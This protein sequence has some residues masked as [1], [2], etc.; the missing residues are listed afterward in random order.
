MLSFLNRECLVKEIDERQS[1]SIFEAS[2]HFCARKLDT[3]IMNEKNLEQRGGLL[4]VD[5]LELL[6]E[7]RGGRAAVTKREEAQRVGQEKGRGSEAQGTEA[8]PSRPEKKP[9][10]QRR[11]AQAAVVKPIGN[12]RD[13]MRVYAEWT[14]SQIYLRLHALSRICHLYTHF[15]AR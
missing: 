5:R 2:F 7:A 11:E 13:A 9:S 6:D 1:I 10:D 3:F 4:L 12:H 14:Q 8:C 15:R